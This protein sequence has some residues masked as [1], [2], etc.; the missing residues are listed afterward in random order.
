M[1]FDGKVEA[2]WADF[3]IF[4]WQLSKKRKITTIFME[5]IWKQ[6]WHIFLNF[7]SHSQRLRHQSKAPR[8]LRWLGWDNET[9]CGSFLSQRLDV[10]TRF[11]SLGF[12]SWDYIL[13]IFLLPFV[14]TQW[15][16]IEEC[17]SFRLQSGSF[18]FQGN[19]CQ[20]RI[21]E[22]LSLVPQTS[23]AESLVWDRAWMAGMEKGH[24]KGGHEPFSSLPR[25]NLSIETPT[26]HCTLVCGTR[27]TMLQRFL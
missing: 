25:Y 22:I 26:R 11:Q 18:R 27:L 19:T 13:D 16:G 9:P 23:Q 5:S 6:P 20:D 24:G 15:V 8:Y 3:Y 14:L 4:K 7:I 21:Q 17:L 2:K 1:Y 10:S 12:I